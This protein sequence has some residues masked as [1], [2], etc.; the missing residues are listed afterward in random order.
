MYW[1]RSM[2]YDDL[3]LLSFIHYLSFPKNKKTT[4][5]NCTYSAESLSKEHI[6]VTGLTTCSSQGWWLRLDGSHLLTW[7]WRER[8]P[9]LLSS[10]EYQTTD[11]FQNMTSST[12]HHHV[13]LLQLKYQVRI[14][15]GLDLWCWSVNISA[16][17][18]MLKQYKTSVSK[19]HSF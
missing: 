17:K 10:P 12:I 8:V 19:K 15:P 5:W 6:A 9:K 2:S 3:I 1:L 18:D 4:F 13:N 14:Y 7:R 16:W 11:K